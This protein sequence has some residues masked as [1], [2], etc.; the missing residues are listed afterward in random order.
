[1]AIPRIFAFFDR[2]LDSS[3]DSSPGTSPGS[4]NSISRTRNDL[5]WLIKN[6]K[7]EYFMNT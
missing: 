2:V 6:T 4:S 3:P 7:A 1:M 5:N